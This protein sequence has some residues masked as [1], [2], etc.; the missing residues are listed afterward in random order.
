MLRA[1][2]KTKTEKKK[3]TISLCLGNRPFSNEFTTDMKQIHQTSISQM[4][5]L[6]KFN[7]S[8]SSSIACLNVSNLNANRERQSYIYPVWNKMM[9]RFCSFC[10]NF[11]LTTHAH[12]FPHI[13]PLSFFIVSHSLASVRAL[14]MSVYIREVDFLRSL[15]NISE[16]M[17][18]LC[19]PRLSIHKSIICFVVDAV[20]I[21]LVVD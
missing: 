16:Q 8:L 3:K 5:V 20:F 10:L 4:F 11:F 7:Q 1:H 18:L 6:V 17:S 14:N 15:A 21:P 12:Y 19:N 2:I 13:F 9:M